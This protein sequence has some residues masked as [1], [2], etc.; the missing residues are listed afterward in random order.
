MFGL[1]YRMNILID[2]TRLSQFAF[3]EK[4]SHRAQWLAEPKTVTFLS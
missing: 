2:S 4:V 3:S 1:R